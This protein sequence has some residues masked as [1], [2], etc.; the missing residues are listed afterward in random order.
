MHCRNCGLELRPS[1]RYC[2]ACGQ[3]VADGVD[4][5][6]RHLFRTGVAELASI[7]S[8]LWRS[9][10]CLLFRP[11]FLSKEYR[12]GR[13][14][15]YLT[16]IGLFLLGNL[17]YFIAP[18]LSDL[19]LSLAEQYELQP[20][21]PWVAGWVDS[22]VAASGQ[23]FAEVA[24]LYQLRIVELAKLMVILHVPLLALGTMLLF[25]D[26]RLYYADHIVMGLHYFA[27]LMLYLISAAALLGLAYWSLPD[28]WLESLAGLTLAVIFL[29]FL[30]VP[31]ML[32]RALDVS[33][34]RA[35]LST[36]LFVGLL[37]AAHFLYRWIQFVIGFT[38][39]SVQ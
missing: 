21:S 4:R 10:R 5:S 33:W 12:E 15:R 13:R 37:L 6:L 16:P 14:R 34:W 9:L 38:L 25:A 3:A 7:D 20:Y 2:P 24:N 26:R 35:I 22:H 17:L 32:K 23:S 8:R 39:V 18:P 31:P 36:P 11:G 27:F 28:Q 19:Q 1:D 30:Y 29:Q